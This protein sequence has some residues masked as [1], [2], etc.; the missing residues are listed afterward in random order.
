MLAEQVQDALNSEAGIGIRAIKA[1][2]NE[3]RVIGIVNKVAA[4]EA[5]DDVAFMLDEPVVNF[6]QAGG[7]GQHQIQCGFSWTSRA[8]PPP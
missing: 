4:A 2:M 6:A 5:F 8:D 3:D 7:D 1:P